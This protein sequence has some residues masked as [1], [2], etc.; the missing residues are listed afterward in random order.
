MARSYIHDPRLD[1]RPYFNVNL[2]L[3]CAFV[4]FHFPVGST[5]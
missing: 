5:Q 2:R 1:P 3:G 4:L